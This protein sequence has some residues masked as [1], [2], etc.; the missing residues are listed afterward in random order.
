LLMPAN[1]GLRPHHDERRS[2]ACEHARQGQPE[3]SVALSQ[4]WSRVP[5]AQ[6]GQLLSQGQIFQGELA[7]WQQEESENAPECTNRS[8]VVAVS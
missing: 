8:H 2:P 1:D 5:S 7:A 3:E 4:A 6:D